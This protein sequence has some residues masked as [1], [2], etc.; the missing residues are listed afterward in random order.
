MGVGQ[1]AFAIAKATSNKEGREAGGRL[2]TEKSICVNLRNLRE[3][4][5]KTEIGE[6]VTKIHNLHK[7][8]LQL[9][10]ERRCKCRTLATHKKVLRAC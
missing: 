4:F 2:Y 1:E 9:E 6:K 8:I 7:L 5:F 10:A 3:L